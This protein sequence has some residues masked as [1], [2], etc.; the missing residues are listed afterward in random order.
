MDILISA[1]E[2]EK[3]DCLMAA[4]FLL[5]QT[6]LALQGWIIAIIGEE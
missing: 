4:L 1:V 6:F 3:A 2:V 5:S